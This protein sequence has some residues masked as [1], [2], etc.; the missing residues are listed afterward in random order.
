MFRT[1]QKCKEEPGKPGPALPD[2]YT[3][4]R[5][6]DKDFVGFASIALSLRGSDFEVLDAYVAAVRL[7]N[8][9]NAL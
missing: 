2:V 6:V 8:S 5:V 4:Y 9:M 1:A 7:I 3:S